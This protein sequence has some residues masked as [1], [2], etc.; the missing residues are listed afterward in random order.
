MKIVRRVL[1]AAM[2]V[3]VFCF[4]PLGCNRAPSARAQ[5][6]DAELG[7]TATQASGRRLYHQHCLVCHEAYSPSDRNGPSLAGLYRKKFMVSGQPV[8]DERVRDLIVLG[9]SKM[10]AFGGQLSDDQLAALLAYMKTL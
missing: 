8:D 9:R 3:P 6:S 5:M 7:L 1:A 10:P 4:A 2:L